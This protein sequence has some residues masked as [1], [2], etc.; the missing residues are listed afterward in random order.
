MTT[1]LE[2]ELSLF[3]V[4][5]KDSNREAFC[6]DHTA[7]G[8]A[9]HLL[10]RDADLLNSS[11]VELVELAFK[12][13]NNVLLAVL[14]INSLKLHF[15]GATNSSSTLDEGVCGAKEALKDLVVTAL[16]NV[17][18]KSVLAFGHSMLQTVLTILVI[19][20]FHCGIGQYFVGLAQLRETLVTLGFFFASIA[21]GMVYQSQIA[22]GFSN[23]FTVCSGVDSERGVVPRLIAVHFLYYWL[24]S[25]ILIINLN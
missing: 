9:E 2:D 8:R 4:T 15:S 19:D 22:V 21:H 13:Y 11:V 7:R 17:T 23:L 16:V 14:R 20:A 6:I 1:F 5:R 25:K 12:R 18:G 3:R 10:T 24:L